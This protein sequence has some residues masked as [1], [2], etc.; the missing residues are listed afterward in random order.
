MVNPPKTDDRASHADNAYLTQHFD[1]TYS[2]IPDFHTWRHAIRHRHWLTVFVN[3][4]GMYGGLFVVPFKFAFLRIEQDPN[5][6]GWDLRV[7]GTSAVILGAIYTVYFILGMSLPFYFRE[8]Q[9]GL[10]WDPS[11]LAS[12]IG[13]LH[14]TNIRKALEGTEFLTIQQLQAVVQTWPC[15]FGNLRL[16]YWERRDRPNDRPV[17]GIHFEPGNASEPMNGVRTVKLGEYGFCPYKEKGENFIRP[18]TS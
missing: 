8:K 18:A 9:T 13:L 6:D 11:S 16:G 14:Q 12:Q 5:G 15:R 17:Y 10:R 1:M 7:S 4:I 2:A 3:I